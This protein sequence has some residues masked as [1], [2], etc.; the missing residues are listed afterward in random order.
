MRFTVMT[1]RVGLGVTGSSNDVSLR[2]QLWQLTRLCG[3]VL[4]GGAVEI[5]QYE[6][7]VA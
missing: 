2:R 3:S 7:H 1:S 4:F 5:E 6:Q